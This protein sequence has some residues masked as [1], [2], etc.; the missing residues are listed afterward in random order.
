MHIQNN[1]EEKRLAGAYATVVEELFFNVPTAAKPSCQSILI[2]WLLWKIHRVRVLLLKK[3][4]IKSECR[5]DNRW[6]FW[7]QMSGTDF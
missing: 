6:K 7:T 4:E 2:F 5:I 1:A 3:S